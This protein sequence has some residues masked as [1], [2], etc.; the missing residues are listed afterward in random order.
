MS[1]VAPQRPIRDRP[2][3]I[4]FVQISLTAVF[5]YG[6]GASQAL[7]R[8]EQGTTRT[9]SGLHATI[10]AV[11]NLISALVLPN[12]ILRFG[13]NAMLRASGSS[14]CVSDSPCTPDRVVSEPP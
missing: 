6:F 4:S 12:L 14:A 5:F 1:L 11:A 10:Y 8:D 13:R 9:V 2:T 3:W 7:L